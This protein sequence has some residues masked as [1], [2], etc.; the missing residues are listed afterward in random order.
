MAQRAAVRQREA[1]RE[2]TIRAATT[3]LDRKYVELLDDTACEVAYYEGICDV[4]GNRILA[5][6]GS[7]EMIDYWVDDQDRLHTWLRHYATA[8]EDADPRCA[9]YSSD[10]IRLSF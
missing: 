6:L 1:R 2:A 3:D 7:D 5:V 9:I 4:C 10:V 8:P